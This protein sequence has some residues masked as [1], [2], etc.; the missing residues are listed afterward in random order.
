MSKAAD[1]ERIKLRA[2]FYNNLAIGLFV[3]GVLLPYFAVLTKV[4]DMHQ[5]M[6]AYRAGTANFPGLDLLKALA[7]LISLCAAFV[8]ALLC[9]NFA[10]REN[11]KARRLGAFAT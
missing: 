6:A 5:W 10:D 7:V 2:T 9:R 3:A 4:P 8:V 1:N 11:S